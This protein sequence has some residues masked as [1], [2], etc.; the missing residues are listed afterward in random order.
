MVN[1][2]LGMSKRLLSIIVNFIFRRI[3]NECYNKVDNSKAL[4]FS[5]FTNKWKSA[6]VPT[7][8]VAGNCTL[9]L[10]THHFCQPSVIGYNPGS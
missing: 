1:F 5:L 10:A 4:M 9:R 7:R 8:K 6:N 3:V 2:L